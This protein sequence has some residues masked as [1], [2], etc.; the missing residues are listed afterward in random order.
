MLTHSLGTLPHK[1]RAE[2][3]ILAAKLALASGARYISIEFPDKASG[4]VNCA[5]SGLRPGQPKVLEVNERSPIHLS[6]AGF[7][8]DLSGR[9]EGAG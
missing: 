5:R 7:V 6:H 2:E 4:S 9:Q 3:R 1:G 8:E